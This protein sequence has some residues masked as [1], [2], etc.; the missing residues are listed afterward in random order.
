MLFVLFLDINECLSNPCHLNASCIDNEGSFHCQCN[1]GFS[2]DG[3]S[4]CASRTL[5]NLTCI[6]NTLY[7]VMDQGPFFFISQTSMNVHAGYVMSMQ[8]VWIPMAHTFVVVRLVSMEMALSVKV[9]S[10]NTNLA[11]NFQLELEI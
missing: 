9:M 10:K 6:P 8:T 5:I 1:V 2:G 4:S 7:F 11:C 3:I